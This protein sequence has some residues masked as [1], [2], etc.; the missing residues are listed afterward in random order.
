MRQPSAL[1]WPLRIAVIGYLV[2]LVIWPVAIVAVKTCHRGKLRKSRGVCDN[3]C[4]AA[5]K[6]LILKTERCPS[7]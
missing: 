6:P 2:L 4:Q 3:L 7:G 5:R 1:R